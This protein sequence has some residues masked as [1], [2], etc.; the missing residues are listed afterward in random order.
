MNADWLALALAPGVTAHRLSPWLERGADA[1]D[2]RAESP[3][4]LGAEG[5]PDSAIRAMKHPDPARMEY[6]TAWLAQPRHFLIPC[7]DPRYPELLRASGQGPLCLF[8]AGDPELLALPQLAIVGSRNASAS[9]IETAHEFAAHLAGCGFIICSGLAL[10]IDTAA[11]T[12]ALDGGG[13]TV[14]IEAT[15]L[16]EVYPRENVAL[17]A[18]ITECGA[19]VSEFA[20]GTSVRRDQFPRRNRIIAGLSVGTLVVE[21]GK[22]S[23]ALITARYSGDFGREVF[24]IPGSIHNPLSKGCH[25]LIRQGAKLVETATDII[26]ELAPLT[27]AMASAPNAPKQPASALPQD[28][29]EYVLLLQALGHDAAS[30]D[31]LAARSGLTAEKLSSMLLILELQGRVRALPG[32]RFQATLNSK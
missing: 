17:A 16:D 31:R 23:G 29:P 5:L 30:V 6:C 11:H 12:G 13:H 28:D 19:R 15:G 1:T 3:A 4:L 21:A 18:R 10:G 9:G 25:R 24:A 32:G 2:V 14:T 8:V 22:T 20:P 27:R 26:E 7:N